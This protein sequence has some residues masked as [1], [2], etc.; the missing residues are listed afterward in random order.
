MPPLTPSAP[1]FACAVAANHRVRKAIHV[2]NATMN[3]GLECEMHLIPDVMDSY[4]PEL[5]TLMN[6]YKVHGTASWQAHSFTHSS[7][8]L[9]TL[10]NE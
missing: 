4:K 10:T 9:L 5:A 3:S 2:G 7:T 6:N 8:H 1:S